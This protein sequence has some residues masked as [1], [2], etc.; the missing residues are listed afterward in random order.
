ME[1][2]L[3]DYL[4][5]QQMYC[6]A[7]M[8]ETEKLIREIHDIICGAYG[9]NTRV[10]VLEVLMILVLAALGLGSNIANAGF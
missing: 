10:R 9:V 8:E 4:A 7:K 3:K 2:D 1:V 5:R 6:M